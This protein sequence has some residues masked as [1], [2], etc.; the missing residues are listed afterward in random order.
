[1]YLSC[2]RIRSLTYEKVVFFDSFHQ[3]HPCVQAW[4]NDRMGMGER[5]NREGRTNGN[6]LCLNFSEPE[7]GIHKIIVFKQCLCR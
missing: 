6:T 7:P 5:K 4:A 1:M 2:L 3:G